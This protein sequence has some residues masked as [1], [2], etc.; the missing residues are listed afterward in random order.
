MNRIDL[1]IELIYDKK[2]FIG[3]IDLWVKFIYGQNWFMGRIDT[4]NFDFFES[5]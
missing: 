5:P 1:W 4:I 2:W 3:T